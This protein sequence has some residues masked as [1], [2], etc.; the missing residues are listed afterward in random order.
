M[1]AVVKYISLH[2][3]FTHLCMCHRSSPTRVV[4]L[5]PRAF[6]RG[7]GAPSE[8]HYCLGKDYKRAGQWIYGH[9]LRYCSAT[10]REA[11]RQRW[12]ERGVNKGLV[13]GPAVGHISCV[14]RWRSVTLTTS[15]SPAALQGRRRNRRGLMRDNLPG[16]R[17]KQVSQLYLTLRQTDTYMHIHTTSAPVPSGCLCPVLLTAWLWVG[18]CAV[19]I[20][21]RRSIFSTC[22]N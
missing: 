17:E 6:H 11:Q 1:V 2:S 8:R 16:P 18:C 15:L 14:G 22:H 7:V 10:A 3:P 19:T 9:W 21:L 13:E 5:V 4:I 20:S 12:G